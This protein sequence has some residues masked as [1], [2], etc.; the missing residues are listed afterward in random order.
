M[1][2]VF[3]ARFSPA[4]LR[5]NLFFSLAVFLVWVRG[6]PWW[7]MVAFSGLGVVMDFFSFAPF[8]YFFFLTGV[9]LLLVT[10]WRHIFAETPTSLFSLFVLAPFVELLV[11]ES[12][13]MYVRGL[14]VPFWELILIKTLSIPTNA[15]F[16][17]FWCWGEGNRN[18]G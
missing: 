6:N 16:F 9:I 12:V 3:L 8:G 4:F 17:L 2:Y 15:F 13:S 11:E 5:L 14:Y 1:I 7:G 10:L 18:V